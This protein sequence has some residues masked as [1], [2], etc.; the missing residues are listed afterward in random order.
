MRIPLRQRKVARVVFDESHGE[1][2]SIRPDAAA[3]MRAEHPAAASYVTA[4]AL[5]AERDFE[6]T[7]YTGGSLAGGVLDDADV[8]VIAHPSA[9]QWER[10]V[11]GSPLLSA[12]EIA[13]IGAFV[14][15]GGGLVVIGETEE[16]KYGANLNALL[17]SFNV[18]IE[19]A[20]VFDYGDPG[21]MPTWVA[22]EAVPGAGAAAV[23]HL[24]DEARFYRAGTLVAAAPGAPILRTRGTAQPPH[25]ALLAAVAHGAGRVV[26]AADSDLFGDDFLG[27]HDHRQLWLNI[28]YWVALAAFR[29][30]PAPPVSTAAQDP[31]W[32]R[33]RDATNAL[34]LLQEPTGEV[35]LRSHDLAAVRARVAAIIEGLDA[36]APRF[37]HQKEYL[38]QVPVDLGAWVDGGCAKPDF[39]ASLALFRPEQHRRDGAEHLVVFP[40][41]TPNGS[42]DTRFEALIVR[43]PW[44]EFVARLEREEFD[45]GQF[46]PVQLVDYT[47]GY[48]SECAVLFPETVSLAARPTNNF[49]AI[50]C[51][52]EASRFRRA[53][54]AGAVALRLDL[55]PD[56]QALVSSSC[57]AIETYIMWDLIHD[58]WHSHGE[59]PF[60]PFMIRQRLPYWMYSL[61]ELRVDL[62]TYGSAAELARRG[63]P[64]AR[65]VQYAILFDRILR[66]PITGDRVRNYDGLGGQLL[67]AF[68]HQRGVLRWSD[69]RLTIDWERIEAEVEA[70]RERVETLYRGGIDMSRV[71]YWAAAHD[72]VAEYVTPNVASAWRREARVVSDEAE[73]R[74]WIDRVLDD[75]FPLSTFYLALQKKLADMAA[76]A[77]EPTR[78]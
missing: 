7:A 61:E 14:A 64:F 56:A 6:V 36:L 30:D 16:D 42:A 15:A 62:A 57:L 75:E 69:N 43:T 26:V 8:I 68:L 22:S 4:A 49:G 9:P 39:T 11:G 31:A 27:R 55:P 54:A 13:A 50:F 33:L 41:Y 52:R 23:L 47:D 32:L 48:D 77:P 29:A 5:L 19:N 24:V 67:F 58:R 74:A 65:Y 72:L 17:A 66:F 78:V 28:F 44:P 34:R 51:D 2:W 70:L 38:E 21:E 20:T 46:V 3:A 45:N 53:T 76:A 60:D 35:D 10:T 71:S 40:M 63:F 18:G 1:A 59:L 73:P 25:A 12:E 37:P